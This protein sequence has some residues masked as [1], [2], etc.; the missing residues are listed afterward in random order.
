MKRSILMLVFFLIYVTSFAL[1][2]GRYY[3]CYTW[4]HLEFES[5]TTYDASGNSFSSH[6]GGV[7][8]GS[9]ISFSSYGTFL[10]LGTIKEYEAELPNEISGGIPKDIIQRIAE[11]PVQAGREAKPVDPRGW[12]DFAYAIYVE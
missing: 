4:N 12:N 2:P 7:I 9:G 3:T 11:S 5:W 1:P 10:V 6:T 8:N